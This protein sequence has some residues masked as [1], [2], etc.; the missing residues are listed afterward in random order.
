MTPLKNTHFNT[1]TT[2]RSLYS[3]NSNYN[4]SD[5]IKSM[6]HSQGFW[7]KKT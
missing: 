3:A 2:T 1:H 4:N 7:E 5:N 6:R